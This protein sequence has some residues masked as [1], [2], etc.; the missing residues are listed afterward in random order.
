ML[1]SLLCCSLLVAVV[2]VAI[3]F[4]GSLRENFVFQISFDPPEY[5]DIILQSIQTVCTDC[6]TARTICTLQ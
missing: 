5:L 4:N 6:C 3:L 2:V 1:C